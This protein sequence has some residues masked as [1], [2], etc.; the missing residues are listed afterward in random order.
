MEKLTLKMKLAAGFGL[1]L[2]LL[3]LAQNGLDS[4]RPMAS[5]NHSAELILAMTGSMIGI[6]TAFFLARSIGGK[7]AKMLIMIQA[8]SSNN[9]AIDDMEVSSRDQLSQAIA[10]LNHVKNSLYALVQSIT[11][12]ALQVAAAS[13]QIS[14]SASRQSQGAD[15]QQDQAVRVAMA[16]QEMSAILLRVSDDANKATQAARQ[17]AET[18]NHG[19]LIVESI[20]IKMRLISGSIADN[21]KKMV[22]LGKGSEQ[23]GRMIGVIDEIADQ[24]NL[25]ALNAAIEA[26]RAGE[27]GRGFAVVADEVRKLAGR[28]TSTT[29][30]IARMIK[31]IQDET[32]AAAVAMEH[33]TIQVEEGVKSTAQTGGSLKEISCTAGQVGDMIHHIA[34]AAIQQ[35]TVTEEIT[36]TMQQIALLIK[37]SALGTQQ[38]AKACEYLSALAF[39]LQ[40]L[41]GNFNLE[42][43]NTRAP[44]DRFPRPRPNQGDRPGNAFAA[45]AH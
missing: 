29:K 14:F 34:A 10:A 7:I 11:A 43:V 27:Q 30:E 9:L 23:I 24:T 35:A 42:K 17:A 5:T 39:D 44:S 6:V 16:L 37:E 36:N 19:G 40:K 15:R 3:L 26:A 32:K 18:A 2:A 21:A 45:G 13:E 8:I 4:E 22:E 41:V 25:L 28:T 38:S 12:T 1:L 20:I 31:N 33:A